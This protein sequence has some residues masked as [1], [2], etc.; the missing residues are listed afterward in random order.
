MHFRIKHDGLTQRPIQH[1]R[2]RGFQAVLRDGHLQLATVFVDEQVLLLGIGNNQ[3]RVHIGIH[4]LAALLQLLL[5]LGG[6]ADAVSAQ[7]G[8]VYAHAGAIADRA[9]GQILTGKTHARILKIQSTVVVGIQMVFATN[10]RHDGL[11]RFHLL[12]TVLDV[13]VFCGWL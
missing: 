10:A 2:Q 11:C 9:Y 8:D 13:D 6:Q 12:R 7:I 3:A 5:A 1:A 4:L